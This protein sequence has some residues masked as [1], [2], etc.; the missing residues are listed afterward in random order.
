MKLYT[1]ISL[2]T[3]LTLATGCLEELPN[4]L[5]LTP[6]SDSGPDEGPIGSTTQAFGYRPHIQ[7]D[8]DG[9]G[10]GI[11][12]CHGGGS[13]PMA[14]FENPSSEAEWEANYQEV[15]ARANDLSSPMLA[16][17]TGDGGHIA[18]LEHDDPVLLRW[19]AWIE[20][21]APYEAD[22]G[23]GPVTGVGGGSGQG[24]SAPGEGLTFGDD[25]AP[26]LA[27][28]DCLNCHGPTN[29][30]GGYS[31][32]S[33]DAVLGFGSDSVPNVIPGDANSVLVLRT[34]EGHGDISYQDALT[35]LSWVVD[36][37]AL[38]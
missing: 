36:W 35:I 15:R 31:L 10:C 17:A 22:G 20:A 25:I 24:G 2:A 27:A 1:W 29:V 28:N 7:D 38:P 18:P 16:K 30:Q 13:L 32:A 9:L 21:G 11:A 37:D 33:Y 5:T 14:L 26:L 4:G 34:E 6:S 19:R 8:L 23:P 12:N 3:A